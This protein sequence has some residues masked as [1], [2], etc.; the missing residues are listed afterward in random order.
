METPVDS[1]LTHTAPLA[2][3]SLNDAHDDSGAV[4]GV[5]ELPAVQATVSPV[6]PAR[7][8]LQSELVIPVCFLPLSLPV[9]PLCLTSRSWSGASNCC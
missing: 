9:S 7:P 4:A 2:S 1:K 8:P 3:R 6:A 5:A